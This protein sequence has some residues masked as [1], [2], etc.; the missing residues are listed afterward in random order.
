[1]GGGSGGH[2]TPVAA[3]IAE[4]KR[5]A[6]SAEVRFWCDRKFA[7][8]AKATMHQ[9]HPDVSVHTIISGKFRRYHNL[10]LWRQLVNVRTIVLPNI[11]DSFKIAA[12]TLESV[13]KLLRWKPDVVFAKGGFVCLPAG[14]AARVLGIP[15]VIHDSDTHAGLT[16]RILS[17]WAV[18][19]GTGAPLEN[20]SYPKAKTH[21]VGIPVATGLAPVS[22]Q[23]QTELQKQFG[24]DSTR[25]LVV[26]TGGGLGAKRINDTTVAVIDN[27]LSICN[28]FLVTG[29][30]QYDSLKDVTKHYSKSQFRI[31]PHV[32]SSEFVQALAAADIVVSRAGATTML[33]MAALAKPTILIPNARLTGGHQVKNARAYEK[34]RAAVVLSEEELVVSPNLLVDT[35]GSLLHNPK[36]LQR[37][38]SSVHAFATPHAARDMAALVIAA[39]K[40]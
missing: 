12:G 10:S 28:V 22:K 33:E 7:R 21:F 32:P 29:S 31:E 39:R 19:I 23:K 30:A 38:A 24:M 20:Y 2:V 40:R 16:S 9:Q 26:V 1:M 4:I 17:R 27:L 37:L 8:E 18:S 5:Q 14:V 35:I 25:P 6:P 34:G 36:E 3:V 15:L 13:Y 11:I